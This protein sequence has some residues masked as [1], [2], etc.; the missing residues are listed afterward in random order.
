MAYELTNDDLD[1]RRCMC[2]DTR[3]TPRSTLLY[4]LLCVS[5]GIMAGIF[6]AWLRGLE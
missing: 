2:M 6:G 1:D 5:A 4:P 3:R